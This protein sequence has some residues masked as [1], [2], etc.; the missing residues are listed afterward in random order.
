MAGSGTVVR[1]ATGLGL[2]AIGFDVDP[3]AVLMAQV[4]TTP[5]ADTLIE[6]MGSALI[7]RCESLGTEDVVLPWI[8]DDR[9]TEA[10]IEYWFSPAQRD[11][12]RRLAFVLKR[13][14]DEGTCS[15]TLA[16]V[17]VLQLA[18]SRIIVTKEQMASLARDTSHSRPH[19]VADQSDFD[20]LAGFA[21]SLK[22]LRKR[23]S[24][25][26]ATIGS[27]IGLGDA[28]A[29]S[30]VPDGSVDAVLT[31]PP[32]LNAIDYLRGHRLSLVWLG[33]TAS[34][35]RTIRATSVGAERAPDH[36]NLDDSV[37]AIAASISGEADLPERFRGMI[38]RYAADLTLILSEISRTLKPGGKATLVVGNSFLK[39]AL[40]RNA[41]GVCK[42]A[43]L[44]GLQQAG[45]IERDL[46][47]RQR[48][49]PMSA[50]TLAKRMRTETIL[51]FAK[52]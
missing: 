39:G 44:S 1:Q 15:E 35:I 19:K 6:Q 22:S 10:F 8:D 25:N 50:G 38:N 47:H 7:Q 28:R 43:L 14:R 16:A 23:L 21:R 17:N 33:H 46:P 30:D 42:A 9:E 34:Q 45:R 52:A 36:P 11:P 18:L 31:S 49:L 32:Y 48:Y 12:L 2:S 51:R 41:E 40:V 4:W 13:L 26:P 20:V 37:K 3:L 5:V 29:L 27:K 24:D